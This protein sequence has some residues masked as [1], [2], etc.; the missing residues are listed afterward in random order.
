MPDVPDC[1]ETL[2]ELDAFLDDDRAIAGQVAL[3]RHPFGADGRVGH[4]VG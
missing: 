1:N 4:V 2:Q 3:A